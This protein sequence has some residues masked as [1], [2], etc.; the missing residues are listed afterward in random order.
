LEPAA[1]WSQRW[2]NTSTFFYPEPGLTGGVQYTVRP[3]LELKSTLSS[4]LENAQ[5]WSFSVAVPRLLKAE[6]QENAL[7]VRLDTPITVTFNQ[8]MNPESVQA[9]FLL[10]DMMGGRCGTTRGM[11]ITPNSLLSLTILH[12]STFYTTQVNAGAKRQGIPLGVCFQRAGSP[13]LC[14]PSP[15]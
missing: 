5:S 1:E 4:P 13:S 10:S 15:R 11:R 9:N 6:P 7:P 8:A 12:F 14:S 2:L 3:N